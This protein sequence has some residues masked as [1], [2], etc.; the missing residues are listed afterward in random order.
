MYVDALMNAGQALDWGIVGV[1]LMP[2]DRQMR[3]MRRS[4]PAPASIADACLRLMKASPLGPLVQSGIPPGGLPPQLLSH[5]WASGSGSR[6][7]RSTA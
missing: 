5:P 4:K 1:G 7:M 6:S 2:Q 3:A